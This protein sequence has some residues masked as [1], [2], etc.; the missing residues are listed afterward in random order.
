M[1]SQTPFPQLSELQREDIHTL[2]PD[3]QPLRAPVVSSSHPAE[4]KP[5]VFP[6]YRP[7][8][9]EP[10]P[11]DLQAVQQEADAI[12]LRAIQEAEQLCETARREGYRQGY[13]QGY[14]EAQRRAEQEAQQA[15]LSTLQRLQAEVQEFLERLRQQSEAYLHQAEQGMLELALETVRKVVKE[16]LRLHPEHALQMVR[17]TLKRI[18][19]FGEVRV[20]VNPLDL[21]QVRQHRTELLAVLDEVPQIEIVEDRR[22]EQGTCVIETDHGTYDARLSTQL[23]EIE[24]ALREVA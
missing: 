6:E 19:T 24:R 11:I 14:A 17:E 12:R 21:S 8:A 10:E 22:V 23:A 3:L 5:A 9:P 18:K 1:P 13:E 7:P 4:P 16:E 2:P 15:L 20:R